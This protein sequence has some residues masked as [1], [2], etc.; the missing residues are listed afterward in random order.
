MIGDHLG[1]LLSAL[2]DDELGPAQAAAAQAHVARCPSCAAELDDVT[3]ARALV[4]AL[5]ALDPPF[6][7]YER[8]LRT[9]EA[10]S[11]TAARTGGGAGWSPRRVAAAAFGSAAAAVM[12]LGLAP[13]RDTPVTPPVNSLVEAH[14]TG[15]SF[16]SD[17]LSRLAP[18]G[19]PV[20]F[21]R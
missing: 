16:G 17:P 15:A 14:A 4:R 9:D 19:V 7:L 3:T 13:P 1:D 6:G 12:L 10:V 8:L 2:V 18:I 5:P 21:R 20:T 11:P